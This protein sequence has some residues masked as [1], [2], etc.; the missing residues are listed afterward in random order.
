MT[1][2]RAPRRLTAAADMSGFRSGSGSLDRWLQRYALANQQ[3]GM[4]TTFVT[5]PEGSPE[6]VGFYSLVTG[7]VEHDAAPARVRRGVPRHPVPVIILARLAVHTE[8]QGTGLGRGLLRDALIRVSNAAGEIGVRT[9]LIHAK[10]DAARK[11]YCAQAEFDPS[12]VD[13]LQLFLLMRDL[14]KAV[15]E[16]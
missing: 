1:R 4:A 12:P 10:D 11:F 13:P 8:H 6:V 16:R 9:L 3:S 5:T 15:R 7:G 14:R 2:Y